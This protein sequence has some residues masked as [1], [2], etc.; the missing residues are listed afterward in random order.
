MAGMHVNQWDEGI[1]P[2]QNLIRSDQPIDRHR[3]ANPTVPLTD[4]TKN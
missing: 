3:L 4:T 1:A 2:V